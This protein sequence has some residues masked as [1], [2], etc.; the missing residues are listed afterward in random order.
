MKTMRSVSIIIVGIYLTGLGLT[1]Y[2]FEFSSMQ[3]ISMS[4][5]V[6]FIFWAV[7]I[8]MG[9]LLIKNKY[10]YNNG[11]FIHV[12]IRKGDVVFLKDIVSISKSDLLGIYNIQTNKKVYHIFMLFQ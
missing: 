10:C 7:L 4:R 3:A 1:C 2:I 8:V 9:G 11:Y 6:D 5:V 12:V